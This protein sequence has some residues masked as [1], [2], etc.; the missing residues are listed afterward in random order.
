MPVKAF[1]IFYRTMDN[2]KKTTTIRQVGDFFSYNNAI[3]RHN[4]VD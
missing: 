4:L 1:F 2:F 3:I